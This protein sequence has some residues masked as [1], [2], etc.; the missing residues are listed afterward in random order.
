MDREAG[1]VS[2]VQGGGRGSV[3]DMVAGLEPC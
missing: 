1:H 2:F 3:D